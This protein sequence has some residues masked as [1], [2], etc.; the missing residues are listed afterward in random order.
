MS[1]SALLKN[2]GPHVRT[3][4]SP[5]VHLFKARRSMNIGSWYTRSKSPPSRHLMLNLV[6]QFERQLSG[7]F[8][9]VENWGSRSGNG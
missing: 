4:A 7:K 6:L 8:K 5:H 2:T 1:G 3:A 9:G